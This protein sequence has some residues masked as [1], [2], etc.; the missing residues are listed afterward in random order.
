MKP[1]LTDPMQQ[2]LL[3]PN[4]RPPVTHQQ[5]VQRHTRTVAGPAPVRN[6]ASLK[7]TLTAFEEHRMELVEKLRAAAVEQYRKLGRPISAND[8]RYVL[9][10]AKYDGDYR[11][12]GSAFKG[13]QWQSVGRVMTNSKLSHPHEIRTFALR[14]E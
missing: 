10:D 11:I 7:R 6:R 1:K 8:I 5:V 3:D 13:K 14:G 12:M 4:H 2:D 9:D